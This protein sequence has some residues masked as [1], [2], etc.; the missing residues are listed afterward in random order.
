MV[1]VNETTCLAPAPV[2]GVFA[3]TE[4][5]GIVHWTQDGVLASVHTTADGGIPSNH[6]VDMAT[7]GGSSYAITTA[8]EAKVVMTGSGGNGWTTGDTIPGAK[9]PLR[10]LRGG[11]ELLLVDGEGAVFVSSDGVSWAR[12]GLPTNVTVT[13]WTM[14]DL[15]G[16]TLALAN[17]SRVVIVDLSTNEVTELQVPPVNDIALVAGHLCI[18]T[19]DNPDVYDIDEGTWLDANITGTLGNMGGPWVD[20]EGDREGSAFVSATLDGLV[21]E[22]EVNISD[23]GGLKLEGTITGTNVSVADM[24]LMANGTVLLAT[25]EGIWMATEGAARAF[26]TV[27]PSM[28]P[29]ND[30]LSVSHS[31]DILWVLTSHGLSYL[32]LDSMGLPSGWSE[33]PDLG[34]GAAMGTLDSAYLEGTHYVCGYGPGIHT[35]DTFASSAPSRWGRAHVH[36]DARDDVTDL[37]V[38]NGTLYTGGPYGL[39]RMV[40]GSDPPEF[41]MVPGSPAGILSL[42]SPSG[43]RLYVGTEKG[44]WLFNPTSSDWSG[45][46]QVFQHLPREPV[47]DITS[48]GSTSYSA[49]G[50]T[51]YRTSPIM[52]SDPLNHTWQDPVVRL[53]SRPDVD[54]PAWCVA[55]GRAYTLVIGTGTGI[56]EDPPPL[57]LYG[58]ETGRDRMGDAFV[59]DIAVTPGGT[60]WMATDSGLHMVD[61]YGTSWTDWTTSDGLSANDIRTLSFVNGDLWIGAYGG[62]DV[63]DVGTQALTRIGVEDGI[64]SNLVYDIEMEGSD[65]WV[66]TDVGGA[67]TASRA[68]LDWREYNT[69]SGLIADDVQAVAVWGDHVLFG[70]DEGVTVLDRS[71]SSMESYTASSSDL[72][73]NWVWCALSHSSGIYVGT[74]QGLARFDPDGGTWYAYSSEGVSGTDVRSLEVDRIGYLWVGTTEGVHIMPKDAGGIITDTVSRTIDRSDGLPGDEVLALDVSSD[75]IMWIGT[76]GG[77]AIVNSVPAAPFTSTG[78]LATFTSRDGLVHDRVNAIEEGPEGTTWLGTSGGLSR[79]TKV[80]Y[81]ARSQSTTVVEDLPDVYLALDDVV[82]D[83]EE[84]NEG[85]TVNVSATVSNPSG[86]RAIV[87]VGLFGDDSGAIGQEITSG[88]AYTEPGGSYTVTLPWTAVGGENVLWLVADPADLVPESNERNNVV[89]LSLH[90]NRYPMI[91]DVMVGPPSGN[92][93]LPHQTAVIQFNFTYYDADGDRPTCTTVSVP[94]TSERGVITTLSGIPEEGIGHVGHVNVPVGNS[95]IEI[96]VSDGRSNVTVTKD[97]SINFA[98]T[99]DG[100]DRG[101]R[102]DGNL[103]F[104]VSPVGPWEGTDIYGVSIRFVEPGTEIDD[105]DEWLGSGPLITADR[106]AEEWVCPVKDLDPGTYDLWVVAMDDRAIYALFLEEDV[107]I[108]SKVEDEGPSVL[109]LLASICIVLAIVSSVVLYKKRG[110]TD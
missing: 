62:V 84:P 6:I 66:G 79:L 94:G 2:G 90:V 72:P 21:I 97:I 5:G 14:A 59:H 64:P 78:V 43:Y 106:E 63:M 35:Y 45:P 52:A 7:M 20:V 56:P 57:V 26:P 33:G 48:S 15:E 67:A 92:S 65:V 81:S 38:V 11:E 36:G 110:S 1:N 4:G 80:D 39:D 40:P 71:V 108:S 93:A 61:R 18:A 13:A 19:D 96:M 105:F 73:G 74:D 55:G 25:D 91:L 49:I 27:R 75:G 34:E 41:E 28:P 17:G 60:A 99:V 12:K 42:H 87:H 32:D 9:V 95:T 68:L 44:Q 54:E 58:K 109:I 23:T 98:I 31:E 88:I 69:S 29:T 8:K 51:V 3:G 102:D 103:R 70:T 85:D 22:A 100:L 89:A 107:K 47:V 101:V 50:R 46:D 82:V 53:A 83:P 10:L 77:A 37:A 104:T 30:M 16:G 24:V 76:S 86:K